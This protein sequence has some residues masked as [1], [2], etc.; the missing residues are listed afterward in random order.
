MLLLGF[1]IEKKNSNDESYSADECKLAC[2][3][4]ESCNMWQHM[5]DRGC[6]FGSSEKVWCSEPET[7]YEG[8]RKC[9]PNFC[10][11]Q[12]SIILKEKEVRE[13]RQGREEGEE[14]EGVEVS[15]MKEGRAGREGR[16]GREKKEKKKKRANGP[17]D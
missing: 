16:G 7:E 2:C 14:G 8:G 9:I 1:G 11:G 6:Y 4:D 17:I 3:K 15:E 5:E 12:E 10:G 13:R